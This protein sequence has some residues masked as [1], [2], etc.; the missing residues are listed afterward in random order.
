MVAGILGMEPYDE[1]LKQALNLAENAGINIL[2]NKIDIPGAHPN[3][4]ETSKGGI[5]ITK[6]GIELAKKLK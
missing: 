2:F 6:T 1:R 3:F 5:A 4:K